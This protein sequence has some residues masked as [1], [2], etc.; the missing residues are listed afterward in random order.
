MV[1]HGNKLA[2]DS[3]VPLYSTALRNE[4]SMYPAMNLMVNFSK[5]SHFKLPWKM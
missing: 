2:S 5:K 1:W 3:S 4:R